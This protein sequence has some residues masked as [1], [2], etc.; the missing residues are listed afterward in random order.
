MAKNE[1]NETIK[2]I[3]IEDGN[4]NLYV[5]D[6]DKDS[7]KFA[8]S[9]DFKLSEIGDKAM[10]YI[11]DLFYYAFR[12]HH[13]DVSR[14]KTDR[15]FFEDL[16]GML[17]GMLERLGQLYSVHLNELMNETGKPKNPKVTVRM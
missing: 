14:E 4:G 3:E 9:R 1:I 11:P 17:P 7:V 10:T 13:K 12:K 8:E 16:G 2:P 15:I 6:F 5:L